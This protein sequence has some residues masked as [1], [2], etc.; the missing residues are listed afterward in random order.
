MELTDKDFQC[1]KD[2]CQYWINRFGLLDWRVD[3]TFELLKDDCYARYAGNWEGKTA[4]LT[5]N[6][7]AFQEVSTDQIRK[8]AFHEVCELLLLELRNIALDE[9]IPFE[10]R[11]WL[12]T[13]AA[14]GVIRRLENSVFK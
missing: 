14:H 10:E 2:E 13:C 8:S 4:T 3:Y 5:L 11:K 12:T 6:K 7:L 9:E 1:F